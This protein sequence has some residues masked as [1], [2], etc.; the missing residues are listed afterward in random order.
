MFR[1]RRAAG[2]A[3]VA[4]GERYAVP[5]GAGGRRQ[6]AAVRRGGGE[7]GLQYET[8]TA[9]NGSQRGAELL[10]ASRGRNRDLQ[11]Y[12]ISTQERTVGEQRKRQQRVETAGG[13]R[14]RD[15]QD[16]EK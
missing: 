14:C 2:T 1:L 4:G 6:A 8:A 12:S 10:P 15:L 9:G 13:H 11:A 16:Q 7:G 5:A 3:G